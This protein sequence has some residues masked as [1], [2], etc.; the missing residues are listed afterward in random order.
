MYSTSERRRNGETG[1][2]REVWTDEIRDAYRKRLAVQTRSAAPP[3]W[4]A[5]FVP[6]RVR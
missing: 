4:D 2:R 6:A 5:P 1:P 3:A